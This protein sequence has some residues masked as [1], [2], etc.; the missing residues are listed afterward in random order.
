MSLS[1]NCRGTLLSLDQPRIM[2]ILNLTPDSFSDGGKYNSLQS[3]IDRLGEMIEAGADI[4]DIG[5][6]SSRPYADE[7]SPEEELARIYPVCESALKHFPHILISVDTFRSTV[8]KEVLDAGI[9]IINDISAGN[10]DKEMM[11]LVAAYENVPYIMMHMQ[12]TPSDMQDQPQYEDILLEIES[13]FV[14]KLKLARE[15]GIKDIVL[16]PGFG[17]G[18][19]L[20]HNYQLLYQLDKFQLFELPILSGISRKSMM[21][22]FFDTHPLDVLEIS[23]ALHLKV[24]ELGTQI[25]RV[26]DIPEAK[27]IVELFSYLKGN[28]II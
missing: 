25:I 17:F 28:G 6:Y 7:V 1:L 20:L 5:G 18:K 22:K 19:S 27:R 3:A 14:E 11:A 4:I 9:H 12:G 16:D 8:A 21:Y 10:L 23:T 24:L 2:G 26:H 15:A 13:F